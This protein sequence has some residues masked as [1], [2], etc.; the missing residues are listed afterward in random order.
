MKLSFI[1]FAAIITPAV[2][3]PLDLVKRQFST[4]WRYQDETLAPPG[5]YKAF[6]LGGCAAQLSFNKDQYISVPWIFEATYADG[7]RTEH[8]PFRNFDSFGVSDP[9]YPYLGNNF[10]TRYPSNSAFTAIHEFTNVCKNGQ[11]PV[12]WRFFTN[13]PNCYT[14]GQVAVVGGVARP[15]QVSGVSLRRI[16]DAG[17]FQVNWSAVSRAV[18][19]SVI[20][21]YPVGTD[22]IGRP[23]LNVRGA[24]VQVGVF[25]PL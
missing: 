17:Y 18:A 5:N 25:K 21:E 23:Y 22:E 4:T 15:A 2:A 1:C 6:D 8:T 9:F 20:V 12:S 10:I 24:R 7:S 14:T 19:Y 11:A 13:F 16:S 3:S